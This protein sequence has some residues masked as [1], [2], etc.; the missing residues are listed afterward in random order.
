MRELLASEGKKGQLLLSSLKLFSELG[1]D[2]V[3]VREIA[4]AAG[5]SEAALYKHF[6]SKEEMALYIFRK[7]ISE[8]TFQ[9]SRIAKGEG[10]SIE[11]LCEI[12]RLTYS[13]YQKDVE[14]IRFA[15]LSQY[16]FWDRLED[17]EKPHFWLRSLLEEGMANGEIAKKPVYLWISLYS[18]LV[19]EPL[20]QYP[21]FWDELPEWGIFTNEVAQSIQHLLSNK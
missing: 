12:Q 20:I 19:F 7:I 13:L 21:F 9:A 17:D 6:P 4:K 14:S 16:Q 1:Y 10:T 15:L 11:R 18:G 8:Y 3:S 2:R 5:V